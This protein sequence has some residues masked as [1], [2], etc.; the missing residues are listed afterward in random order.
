MKV[1]VRSKEIV[2]PSSPTPESL[3]NYKLSFLDQCALNVRVPFVF[4][5]DSSSGAYSHDHTIDELKK[6][7]S[8]TLSLM[9]PLAGRVKE[10]KLT[11]ECNDEGVEFIVADVA[12]IM[13]CLLENPE[14]E[15][16]KLLIPIG[17]V[18]EPQP[19][20]KALVAVQVN[21]F[22]CG[23]IGFGVSVSHAIADASAVAIFFETWAS[24]NRGC[25]VNGNGFISDQSTILFPPLT[26][27]SAIERSVK[28]A[29][30]AV[31]QEGKDMI[32]KRFVVPAKA[33][34]QLREELICKKNN[35]RSHQRPSRTEALTALVWAAVINATPQTQTVQLSCMVNLRSRMEPPLPPNCL[36]SLAYGATVHCEAAKDGTVVTAVQLVEKIR[37]SLRAVNDGAARKIYGEGGLLRAAFA[38]GHEMVRNKDSST[39]TLYTSSL[40][41]QPYYEVDFGWGKPRLVVNLLKNSTVLFLDTIGG[42]VEVWMGLPKEVMHALMQNRHF[43]TYVS[44]SPK[45]KL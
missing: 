22:S 29:A 43:L 30:E 1:E 37:D 11:I 6:S 41:R 32:V 12:E 23:G 42:A 25:A 44:A 2:R 19:V 5:Y 21:R 26:D 33:I 17:K 35:K 27:T 8:E 16:I 15:K 28:M 7:L 18:Y 40:L 14:M 38:R 13:S 31:E 10:D 3:K 20:G 24:I 45:P 39:T 36:G 9:Y 4:F 34:A